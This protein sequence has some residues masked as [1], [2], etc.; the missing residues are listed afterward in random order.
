M[1]SLRSR[2]QGAMLGVLCGDALGAPYETWNEERILDDV[3]ERDGLRL[4]DYD[5]PW[6]K[7]GRFPAGRPTDDSE[8][9]AA[10]AE[11]L[12]HGVCL[13]DLYRRFRSCVIDRQ[14]LLCDLPAYGFG[15][16]TRRALAAATYEEACQATTAKAP[17]PSNGSLMRTVPVALRYHGME[18]SLNVAARKAA[19]ITH[20]HEQAID[21]SV[22]YVFVLD[23]ILS[24]NSYWQ[25]VLA[26][27]PRI[28][29]HV[30]D[31]E[32][33][34]IFFVDEAPKPASAG[35]FGGSAVHT[36]RVA[37]FALARSS[38][39]KEGIEKAVT[40]GGDTDTYGAVAGGL[41]GAQYGV[42]AIP[43]WWRDGLLGGARMEELG[44]QLFDKRSGP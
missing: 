7:D 41:L 24:G 22:A 31:K 29:A 6:G 5:D 14:S 44:L 18:K 34:S 36:L 11:H 30:F 42:D 27:R 4:F 20:R 16:T 32:V 12:V 13:E 37:H 2:Y 40:I 21:A 8:L 39:F 23:A 3:F 19:R 15:G 26:A 33:H 28:A 25:A 1:I 9:T 35:K 38:S 17:I 43:S 10:L